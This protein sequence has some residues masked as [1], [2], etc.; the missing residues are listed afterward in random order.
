MSSMNNR[1]ESLVLHLGHKQ[2]PLYALAFLTLSLYIQSVYSLGLADLSL[3]NKPLVVCTQ[4]SAIGTD[5][6]EE[7]RVFVF[8]TVYDVLGLR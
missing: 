7:S 3:F 6:M 5:L 1:C 4:Y 8:V 2:A